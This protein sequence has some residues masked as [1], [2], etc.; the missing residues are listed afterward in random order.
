MASELKQENVAGKSRGV[1]VVLSLAVIV[2]GLA[3]GYL[4]TVWLGINGP[5]PGIAKATGIGG[6][7][8]R[9]DD[10]AKAWVLTGE[11]DLTAEEEQ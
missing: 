9:Y 7:P 2:A 11:K 8:A 1:R 4:G 6:K 3:V 5:E 10:K